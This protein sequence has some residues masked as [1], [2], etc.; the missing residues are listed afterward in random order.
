MKKPVRMVL[1]W[2]SAKSISGCKNIVTKR[3]VFWDFVHK[4]GIL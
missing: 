1:F 4:P 2:V 3:L